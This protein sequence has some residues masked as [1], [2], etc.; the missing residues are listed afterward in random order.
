MATQLLI[1]EN[2]APVSSER[3]RD[4]WVRGGTDYSFSARLNSVPIT[5][6]EFGPA[7]TEYPIVFA[8]SDDPMPVALLGARD[9]EN[10]FVDANGRW[11][12]RY[13]PA[14]LRRYPF[15]FATPADGKTY[16]LCI[17]EDFPGC[18]REGRGERLFDAEGNR[19]QFLENALDFTRSY[20]QQHEQTLAFARRLTELDLLETMQANL[21][22]QSGSPLRLTGFRTVNRTRLKAL[23]ADTIAVLMRSD[24]LELVF[25]HLA[26]LRHFD[27]LMERI[28]ARS[29]AG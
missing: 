24:G 12:G 17:D 14:F 20:Q 25:A 1:Y 22:L 2:A 26:S 28:S 15:V 5:A 11:T 23:P 29:P 6:A 9:S 7:G 10:L 13:V 8:G 19:T 3:H 4:L 18:N 21:K 16:R 27:L